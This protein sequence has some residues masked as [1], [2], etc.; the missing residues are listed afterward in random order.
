M[1]CARWHTPTEICGFFIF[2][3]I[4]YMVSQLQAAAEGCGW[5]SYEELLHRPSDVETPAASVNAPLDYPNGVGSEGCGW[6]AYP[7]LLHVE[8]DARV[9]VADALS[10]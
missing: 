5:E 10:A 2:L 8:R 7:E 3:T 6:D 4:I 1:F 9:A